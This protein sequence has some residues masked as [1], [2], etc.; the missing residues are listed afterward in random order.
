MRTLR[1]L[2]RCAFIALSAVLALSAV[3]HGQEETRIEILP[4]VIVGQE[5]EDNI[6]LT[7]DNKQSDFIT[8]VSPGII[9]HVDSVKNKLDLEYFPTWVWYQEFSDKDTIRHNANMNFVHRFTRRFSLNLRE[10]YLRTEEPYA[11]ALDSSL[12]TENIRR[13]RNIYERN[14]TDASVKYQF[15]RRDSVTLGVSQGLLKNEDPLID[16]E[17]DFGPYGSLAYWL[18][19]QNGVELDFRL[20]SY[21][22]ERDDGPSLRQNLD[23]YDLKGRYIHQFKTN[24]RVFVGYGIFMR[25]FEGPQQDYQIHEANA[26]LQHSFSRD[27]NFALDAGYFVPSGGLTSNGGALFSGSLN[28]R[29]KNGNFTFR[30]ETGWDEGFQETDARGFTRYWGASTGLDYRLIKDMTGNVIVSYRQ[31]DYETTPDDSILYGSLGLRYEV[32]KRI[33]LGLQYDYLNVESEEKADGYVD[34]KVLMTLSG[35]YKL[36]PFGEDSSRPTRTR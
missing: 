29:I 34:N 18:D 4:T 8:T 26:G 2:I 32:S 20:T 16:D 10:R 27:W 1:T 33:F 7:R 21:D 30:V 36:Y 11:Q 24:T 13:T 25:S 3:S 6:F 17:S 19:A 31:N 12:R 9:A 35:S 22:Y 28:R 5:Y 15:G 14:D 23:S